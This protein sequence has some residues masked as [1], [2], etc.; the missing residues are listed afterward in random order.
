MSASLFDPTR[1][2]DDAALA[3][4]TPGQRLKDHRGYEYAFIRA[5]N[6]NIT[7]H[8]T[9]VIQGN[10]LTARLTT[11]TTADVGRLCGIAFVAIPHNSYGWLCI[12]GAGLINVAASCTADNHLYTTATAGRLDDAT[13]A[14][15]I[16]NIGL[17]SNRGA[18][19]QATR[20]PSGTTRFATKEKQ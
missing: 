13:G 14:A 9:C 2:Y 11:T 8:H 1:V 12:W 16:T 3:P 15:R 10:G 19:P 6:A 4:H 20:M 7:A 5:N 18:I 17:T